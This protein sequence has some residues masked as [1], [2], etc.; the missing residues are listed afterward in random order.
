MLSAVII[1]KR[2]KNEREKLDITRETFCKDV[3][4]T[5]SALSMYESGHRIPRDEVKI[6]IAKRLG[7]SIEAL[8][9]AK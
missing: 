1:G 4:I 6:R 2:I 3:D 5:N 9:F 7:M 8:F